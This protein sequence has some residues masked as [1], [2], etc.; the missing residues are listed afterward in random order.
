MDKL[1][2]KKRI[3]RQTRKTIAGI[4]LPPIEPVEGIKTIVDVDPAYYS[5]VEG[6]PLKQNKSIHEYKKHIK[7]V[8]LNRTLHGFLV[9][10]ILRIDREIET[11]R[12]I[13]ET[14]YKHFEEYQ[15][16]FDKFLAD[17]NN[18]TIAI[19]QKSDALAK[20]LANQTENHK[21]A[22]YDMASLKSKLQYIDETLMI[23]LSFQNFLYKAS[24]ILWQNNNNIKLDLDHPEIFVMDSDV[25]VKIDQD[26]IEKKLQNL[27]MPLLYFETP[28][29]LLTIF[30]LLEKQNLNYLL[31][32]TE[33]NSEKNKFLKTLD[34]LK[35]KL[36]QELDFIKEKI[37]EIQ[38]TIKWNE[39]REAEI[40][41]VFYRILKK[42]IRNIVSSD[43]TLQ[44]FNYVEFAYEQLVAPNETKFASLDMALALEREY[45]NLTLNISVY[46]LNMIK[47]IEKETYEHGHIEIKRAKEAFKLL[48]DVDKLSKRLKSS[49]EPTRRK[50]YES[51][52]LVDLFMNI[53]LEDVR[54]D[55]RFKFIAINY[56]TLILAT[57]QCRI[58]KSVHYNTEVHQH[59]KVTMSCLEKKRKPMVPLKT[60]DIIFR[61]RYVPNTQHYFTNRKHAMEQDKKPKKQMKPF[62]V[63]KS[64]KLLSYIKYSDRKEKVTTRERLAQPL[65]LKDN[66]RIAATRDISSRL[67]VEEPPDDVRAVVEIHPEFYTVIEGRPLRCFDDIKVYLNNI[68]A[69]AMNRQQIGYRRDLILKIEKSDF[70]ESEHYEKIVEKLKQHIKNFQTFLTEDYKKACYKVAR[71]EKVYNTLL[72]KDSEFLG[73]VSSLTILN[74]ILFKLDAIRRILKTYRSYL[75]FVAPLSWRQQNDETLRGR[76]MS[77]QF[78][79]GEFATDN[80]LV[81]SLDIEKTVEMAKIELKNPLPACLF[82]QKPEQM[83]YLFRSMELQSREYL[84]QLAKTDGPNRSL[85]DRT[86]RLKQGQA[87]EAD[88]FQYYIDIINFEISRESFNEEHLRDK[89]YRILNESFYDSIASPTTLKLKICIEYVY[90]QVFGKCEEG[91]HSLHDPLKILEVM[92]EDYNLRLDALDFQTVCQAQN[93]FFAQDLKMMHNAYNAQRE[94]RAFREMTNAMNKAFWPPAKFVRAPM[95]K[96]L[97]KRKRYQ[98]MM[99]EKKKTE[100]LSGERLKPKKYK[101]SMEEREGLLL[102]TDWCEGM[103]PAPFLKEYNEFAKPVFEWQPQRSKQFLPF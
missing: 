80:D 14:A 16:S 52:A 82:F 7:S 8:A 55:S 51:N 101:L 21:K 24:P 46:D 97:D 2:K 15:N 61:R 38:D 86:K 41:E 31:L 20:E 53:C 72:A 10:E 18:K 43:M 23:L 68:R 9:D 4:K 78:E 69:Y 32:T 30:D 49:Y 96:F 26:A 42:K 39:D 79:A 37:K 65:F 13:Y 62:R 60:L 48:K 73:Y 59:L 85:R 89:F 45:D 27:P 44:I 84:I 76:I 54:L 81:E 17:D 98:L 5:L 33:F 100:I 66:L 57:M 87:Q 35:I 64:E 99:S 88:Y 47:Q 77:I 36:R 67:F 63:P 74:N 75:M 34:V 22:N 56:L 95:K 40:K 92:Y 90:E 6:R 91:H 1:K 19:M 93:D 103:N 29:Q 94:L 12:N 83:M 71:A 11:E 58:R 3:K 102:F 25:F 70:E 50:I 28:K